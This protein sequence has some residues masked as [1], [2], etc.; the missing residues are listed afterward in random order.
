MSNEN[1]DARYGR[2]ART[3]ARQR[4]ILITAGI[5]FAVVLGAWLIFATLDTS[6]SNIQTRNIGYTLHDE[7]NVDVTYE[8]SVPVGTATYCAVQALSEQF[9]VVGWKIVEVP[10]G[11]AFTRQFTE[12]LRTLD[13]AVTGLIYSC[14]P[15]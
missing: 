11:D 7:H 4:A 3:G 5:T 15:A 2:T 9:G 1:L 8:L 10:P 6:R 12:P 14:W 13:T